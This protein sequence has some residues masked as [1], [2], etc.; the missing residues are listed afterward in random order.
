MSGAS[1]PGALGHGGRVGLVAGPLLAVI[2]WCLPPAAGLSVEGQRLAGVTVVH[3][4]G[5]GA[6][7]ER[8]SGA[9]HHW[10]KVRL[11][12][13]PCDTASRPA[14]VPCESRPTVDEDPT[15]R[16]ALDFEVFTF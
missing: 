6:E 13:S 14:A 11:A 9:E 12:R 3:T 4:G 1:N 2:V 5:A 16:P 10:L 15:C 7:L 8:S